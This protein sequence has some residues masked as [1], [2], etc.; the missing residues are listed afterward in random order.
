MKKL[1]W[2]TLGALSLLAFIVSFVFTLTLML[3]TVNSFKV[4]VMVFGMTLVLELAKSY[5]LYWAVSGLDARINGYMRLGLFFMSTL[6]VTIS[7][8]ASLAFMINNNNTTRNQENKTSNTRKEQ[9]IKE[10]R[11]QI[12]TLPE[13]YYSKK[14]KLMERVEQLEKLINVKSERGYTSFFEMILNLSANKNK[15]KKELTVL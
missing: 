10:Y 5:F 12:E 11:S 2:N 7:I 1:K 13:N 4:G 8:I 14:I 6:L 15:E 3:T 9:M